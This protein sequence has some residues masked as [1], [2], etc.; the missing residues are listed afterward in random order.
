MDTI[1]AIAQSLG[2]VAIDCPQCRAE[3]GLP[4]VRA[5]PPG[6]LRC[7]RCDGHGRLW[8]A[9]GASIATGISDAELE[10]RA[11]RGRPVQ[12]GGRMIL[13]VPRT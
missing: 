12:A 8:C 10:A 9:R 7:E 2:L 3:S 4:M 6:A 13:A 5:V 1:E 11:P